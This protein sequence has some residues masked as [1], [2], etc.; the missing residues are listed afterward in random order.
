MGSTT[1]TRTAE[2]SQISPSP[3]S[4]VKKTRMVSPSTAGASPLNIRGERPYRAVIS[5]MEKFIALCDLLDIK[6]DAR[7]TLGD[8]E[9]RR[10]GVRIGL[11]LWDIVK[12]IHEK[13]DR[14]E[15]PA[16][17]YYKVPPFIDVDKPFGMRQTDPQ[18]WEKSQPFATGRDS[19]LKMPR[20]MY[21]DQSANRSMA[22]GMVQGGYYHPEE[23]M[24]MDASTKILASLLSPNK[25]KPAHTKLMDALLSSESAQA[26]EEEESRGEEE[27][28][29]VKVLDMEEDVSH[30]SMGM[31]E[32]IGAG[33]IGVD[34]LNK[35]TEYEQGLVIM[36]W[37]K[38]G[39]DQSERTNTTP[40]KSEQGNHSWLK[41]SLCIALPGMVAAGILGVYKL[42]GFSAK[43]RK[44]AG[45]RMHGRW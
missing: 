28:P 26:G 33:T 21:G 32:A 30:S 7:I 42:A 31:S 41:L 37:K 15:L 16:S 8:V 20:S 10:A 9:N 43:S 25:G 29:V 13:G 27:D 17:I 35:N 3:G 2:L 12:K 45:Q 4:M 38:A 40:L 5:D 19:P 39:H 44:R 23:E 11:C 6:Q 34:N 24:D 1:T 18:S 36:P 22:K 14:H